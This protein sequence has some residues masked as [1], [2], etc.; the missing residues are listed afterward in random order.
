M[1]ERQ[2]FSVSDF[3]VKHLPGSINTVASETSLRAVKMSDLL[4]LRASSAPLS[5]QEEDTLDTLL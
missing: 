5:V 1:N 4:D 3:W 2:C